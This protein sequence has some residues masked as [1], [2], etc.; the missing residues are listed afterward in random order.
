[1]RPGAPCEA[2][3]ESD[4]TVSDPGPV[5][6]AADLDSDGP[7]ADPPVPG[8]DAPDPGLEELDRQLAELLDARA[9]HM[10]FEPVVDLLTGQVVALEARARGPEGS[11]LAAPRALFAAAR[12]VG[13]VGELDWVC[14]A[15]AF[16]AFMDAGVLP[17]VSLLVDVEPEAIGSACPADVAPTITRAES[18]LR[19]Y[20]EV[21]DRALVADPAGVLA[22]VDRARLMGWGVAIGNVGSSPAPIAMLPIV[23]PDVVKIDLRRL[24]GVSREDSSAIL[25]GVLRHAE[26][27]GAAVVAEGVDSRDDAD[28]ARALGAVC[29]QGRHLGEAGPLRASYPPARTPVPLIKVPPPDLQ[30][31]S[32]FE[33]FEGAPMVRASRAHLFELAELVAHVPRTSGCPSVFLTC[34]GGRGELP[35]EVVEAR[36]PQSALFFV[37]FGTDM[38]PE[39]APGARGVR[40]PPGDAFARE[41][42]LIVLGDQAPAAF[43]ARAS[44]PGYYDAVVTQDFELVHEIARHIIRRVP[45]LG[46]DN[47]A[48]GGAADDD[49]SVVP[50][51]ETPEVDIPQLA[52]K[53]GWRGWRSPTS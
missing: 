22:A 46:E 45:V 23:G 41:D 26:R 30:V 10:V 18:R 40:L 53:R 32:P 20:V 43:F 28:W 25:A 39:P 44:Q 2:E 29:G 6:P 4:V 7:D 19:V 11:A 14:R 12:R 47:T 48:L 1:M 35:A 31:A 34:L 17:S 50:E 21:D 42:F 8:P 3:E 27:T 38:P 49:E 5:R 37:A 16:A 51:P 9:V 33:L 36:I 52:H 24:R 15:A 13:R